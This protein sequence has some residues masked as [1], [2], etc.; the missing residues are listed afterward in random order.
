SAA[1]AGRANPK[2][3]AG[4]RPGA[5]D[6]IR[7]TVPVEV[8]RLDFRAALATP[9]EVVLMPGRPQ[10]AGVRIDR[11]GGYDGPLTLTLLESPVLMPETVPV[12]AG[13][14]RADVPLKLKPGAPGGG[15]TGRVRVAAPKAEA[16]ADLS[17]PVR[18]LN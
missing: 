18:L 8:R 3:G 5:A 6:E 13:E 16:S 12:K 10:S 11:S 17:V 7:R 1:R 9:G 14:T 4:T 15:A 2:A